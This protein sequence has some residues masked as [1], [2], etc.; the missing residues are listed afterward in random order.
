MAHASPRAAWLVGAALIALSAPASSQNFQIPQNFGSG[1]YREDPASALGRYLRVITA[2]PRDLEALT[3]AGRAALQV[4]DAQ[5][6]IGFYARAEAISPRNGRIKAGLGSALVLLNQEQAALKY[7]DEAV[8]LGVPEADVASDRGLAYDLRGSAK[9]AQRDYGIA[10]KRGD[11]AETTRR[12]ALSMAISGDG[13]GALVLLD[14]L[15]RK[16]DTAAWRA[17]AFILA[18]NGDPA[19]AN[20]AAEAV[21]PAATAAGFAPF[22]RKLPSLR[23]GEK[24]AAV[25]FGNFPGEG[26]PMRIDDLF[27]QAEV[28]AR[29]ALENT[30]RSPI[31]AG[32]VDASQG[33]FGRLAQRADGE[34]QL[35]AKLGAR[36][37]AT[38]RTVAVSTPRPNAI[39]A[40][41]TSPAPGVAASQPRAVP[42]AT[43]ALP[44]TSGYRGAAVSPS[45][46]A[47]VL[48]PVVTAPAASIPVATANAP[49]VS[50][51]T[52]AP[53]APASAA[54]TPAPAPGFGS[55]VVPAPVEPRPAPVATTP[56]STRLADISATVQAAASA[57]IVQT[58][59]LPAS[60]APT[61]EPL[62]A[63]LPAPA[64]AALALPPAAAGS[65]ASGP[66]VLPPAGQRLGEVR[67]VL[68]ATTSTAAPFETASLAR[69]VA[70]PPPAPQ[71]KVEIAV[72]APPPAPKPKVEIALA[73]PPPAPRP[74]VE[75]VTPKPAEPTPASAAPA[76]TEGTESRVWVQ[77]AGGA[78]TS[79]FAFEWKRLKGKAPDLLSTQ[80]AW[81]TPLKA[82]NRLLV[83]PFGSEKDAQEFVNKL[84]TKGI[85]AFAWTSAKDQAIAKLASR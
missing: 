79:A 27:N 15:L 16:Q 62:P 39:F 84:A 66:P 43:S 35:A 11:D 65:T 40:P 64:P 52:I 48:T 17:R 68:A 67:Q 14:P 69:T 4:G 23:P 41:R 53:P 74:K 51:P 58:V 61:S 24:A 83:G 49:P 73:V 29:V 30:P 77:V 5:A 28:A 36:P 54:S 71:P 13:N 8:S 45:R 85:S 2:N 18:M 47:T 9:R 22:F 72:A 76:A 75:A 37:P 81:T 21:M 50:V 63:P 60:T 1:V 31:D 32:Q 55:P 44:S 56:A 78:D 19:A 25:H 6:A 10:L 26:R 59:D 70:T 33:A 7:F 3:G 38:V 82:T 12:L 46:L 57:P 42:P 20:K 80:T 34:G